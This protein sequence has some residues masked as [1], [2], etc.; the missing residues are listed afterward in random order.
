MLEV[1]APAGLG[2]DELPKL[3]AWRTAIQASTAR[4]LSASV[5]LRA[6]LAGDER[7]PA[8]PS[9]Q[10]SRSGRQQRRE[11]PHPASGETGSSCKV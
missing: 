5:E 7:P 10:A 4:Y 2:A 11:A 8:V 3:L 1:A 6:E 9:P